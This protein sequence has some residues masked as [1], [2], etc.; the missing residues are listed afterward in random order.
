MTTQAHKYRRVDARHKFDARE[1]DVCGSSIFLA[2]EF[3]RCIFIC[4]IE[5]GIGDCIHAKLRI[6]D[7]WIRRGLVTGMTCRAVAVSG[8]I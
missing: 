5:D 7:P 2:N 1:L 6:I 3:I 8:G 4:F